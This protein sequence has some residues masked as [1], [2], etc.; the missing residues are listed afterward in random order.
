MCLR[1]RDTSS[2]NLDERFRMFDTN[3]DVSIKG[4]EESNDAGALLIMV[5]SYFDVFTD[6][7]FNCYSAML[8]G[9]WLGEAIILW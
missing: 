3:N 9:T 5:F 6:E 7:H 2:C 4:T 1:F 8:F